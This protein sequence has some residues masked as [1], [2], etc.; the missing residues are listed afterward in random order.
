MFL[1]MRNVLKKIVEKKRKYTFHVK[2]ISLPSPSPSIEN[3][4]VYGKIWKSQ[5]GK[6]MTK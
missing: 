2:Y 6:E 4:A 1:R 3:S 5:T